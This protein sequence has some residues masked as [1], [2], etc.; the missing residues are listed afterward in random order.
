MAMVLEDRIPTSKISDYTGEK[1]GFQAHYCTENAPSSNVIV[2]PEE[3]ENISDY[4][5]RKKGSKPTT[6]LRML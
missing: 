3:T 5:E 6:P 4:T 2:A 1:E